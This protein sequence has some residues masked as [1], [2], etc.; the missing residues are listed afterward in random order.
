MPG[1]IEFDEHAVC[2]GRAVVAIGVEDKVLSNGLFVEQ[3]LLQRSSIVHGILEGILARGDW[4][5]AVRLVHEQGVVKGLFDG[6]YARFYANVVGSAEK[7]GG[8]IHDSTMDVLLRDTKHGGPDVLYQ[9]ALRSDMKR[10]ELRKVFSKV[11]GHLD[12]DK[13]RGFYR[14]LGSLA[15]ADGEFGHAASY[16]RDA[17]DTQAVHALFGRMLERPSHNL[18]QLL[19]IAK[20][21]GD[22][23]RDILVRAARDP[24]LTD[25]HC[26][27]HIYRE[28]EKARIVFDEPD[29]KRV[30]ALMIDALSYGEI[31]THKSDVCLAWALGHV[32]T[33]AGTAYEIFRGQNYAGVERDEAVITGIERGYRHSQSSHYELH[34]FGVDRT[35]LERVYDR[36]SIEARAAVARVIGLPQARF[37]ALSREFAAAGS[38]QRAYCLWMEGEGSVEDSYLIG[39]RDTLIDTSL[40]DARRSSFASPSTHWLH[41][42]D[43]VGHGIMYDRAVDEFPDVAY[44]L[45]RRIKDEDRVLRSRSCMIAASPEDALRTF[46]N[47]GDDVGTNMALSTLAEK[48]HVPYETLTDLLKQS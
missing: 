11:Q 18:Y 15:V 29:R 1:K 16:Y 46:R 39:L 27:L 25:K 23:V 35:D 33:D 28:A 2:L 22:R 43:A 14:H 41:H 31:G 38:V 24:E 30:V 10:E 34:P 19:G 42:L 26:A 8:P 36:L 20:A 9:V 5:V 7:V 13:R 3:D 45:A 4:Q 17:G 37:Q 6:D 32:S 48:Y 21:D 12:V 40:A 47:K 44:D